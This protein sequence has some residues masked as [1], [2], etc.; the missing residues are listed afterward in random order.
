M[1]LN[2]LVF[3]IQRILLVC[4]F[5]VILGACATAKQPSKSKWEVSDIDIVSPGVIAL[6]QAFGK[7]DLNDERIVCERRRL[8]GSNILKVFCQT[9]KEKELI[10]DL[11][12]EE[13]AL[14]QEEWER[15]YNIYACLPGYIGCG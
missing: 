1:K 15:R 7:I 5:L 4:F 8:T 12:E 6:V 2:A 9:R 14:I 3:L 10:S 11:A 13:L